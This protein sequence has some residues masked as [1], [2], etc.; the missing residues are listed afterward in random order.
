MGRVEDAKHHTAG[1]ARHAANFKPRQSDCIVLRLSR[2]KLRRTDDGTMLADLVDLHAVGHCHLAFLSGPA[3]VRAGWRRRGL[4][5]DGRK[6]YSTS[7]RCKI[8]TGTYSHKHQFLPKD[9]SVKLSIIFV[10]FLGLHE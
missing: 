7:L 9:F 3:I 10:T 8:K 2:E 1:S 6:F 5:E 4:A